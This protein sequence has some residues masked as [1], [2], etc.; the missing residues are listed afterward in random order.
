MGYDAHTAIADPMCVDA[1]RDD[2]RLTPDSPAVQLGFVP[3]PVEK[4]G[5]HAAGREN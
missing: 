4:I 3:I 5:I 2:G 1:T